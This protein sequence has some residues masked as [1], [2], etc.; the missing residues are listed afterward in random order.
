MNNIGIIIN[1]SKDGTGE[2]LK[3]VENKIK[4]HLKPKNILILG[5]LDN[6][7]LEELKKIDLIVVLGGD[8]TI[9]GV[10]RKLSKYIKCPILGVNIGN[11][12]FIAS[13][14]FN[15]LDE[16]LEAFNNGNYKVEKRMM[17]EA[18]INNKSFEGNK[19]LN[20]IV[21]ARGTL[22]RMLKYTIL[23]DGEEYSSFN[24]DGVIISTPVGST[25][26]SLSAGGPLITPGLNLILIV[27]ICSHGL[28]TKP[29]IVSGNSEVSIIPC[30]KEEAYL[31]IDGQ[32]SMK[33]N[34]GDFI[35]INQCKEEFNIITFSGKNYFKI[36][37][38]KIFYR[39]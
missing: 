2:F 4:N 20:D 35:K 21:I 33:L 7:Q 37:K 3:A 6:F 34:C 27:P 36:L 32:K 23:V 38:N 9:L 26:Y 1:K 10:A 31:T 5:H 8:G 29:L 28:N 14:E 11:L 18:T 39:M 30:L 12:G 13:I 24:G 19:A 15:E 22:S 16:A 25:A 17:I